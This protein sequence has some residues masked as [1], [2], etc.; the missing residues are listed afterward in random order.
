MATFKEFAKTH[1]EAILVDY[2]APKPAAP[3]PHPIDEGIQGIGA[4]LEAARNDA[5]RALV[6]L[7]GLCGLR[8]SEARSVR[9]S[10]FDIRNPE[11]I[12]LTVRGKG[13]KERVVPVSADAW[14]AMQAAYVSAYSRDLTLVP[15]SDSGA[16]KAF[17]R[18][19]KEA[20]L[21]RRV[22]SHD[23]R[24]TLATA[25]LNNGANIRTVQEILGHSNVS[26]TQVYTGVTLDSMREAVT[27]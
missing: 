21:S 15:L 17:T 24:A 4:M 3:R 9:P 16:R 22:A 19:G 23:G 7:T 10:M 26:T 5:E 18:I 13:D 2:R 11:R 25:A 6:A 1:G 8:V 20:G 12:T 14:M 27:F